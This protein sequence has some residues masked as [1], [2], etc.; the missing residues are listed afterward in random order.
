MK[1]K[2]HEKS[3]YKFECLNQSKEIIEGERLDDGLAI[4]KILLVVVVI[5]SSVSSIWWALS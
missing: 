3:V 1:L 2:D 5:C 4:M